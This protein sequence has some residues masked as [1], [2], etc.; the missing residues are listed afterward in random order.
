QLAVL[1]RAGLGL[2]GVA[3]EV[4][5]LAAGRDEA[6]LDAGREARAAAAAQVRRLDLGGDVLGA[7]R[8][9]LA[10]GRVAAARLVACARAR[11]VLPEP[12][13]HELR[14]SIGRH[15]TTS[16][17]GCGE[18]LSSSTMPPTWSGVMSRKYFV[19]TTAHGAF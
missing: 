8:E 11:A 10:Q 1:A 13:R 2:V 9:R 3:H 19:P 17:S 6:P 14:V 16:L 7:H 18:R 15:H 5:G 4:D 12:R